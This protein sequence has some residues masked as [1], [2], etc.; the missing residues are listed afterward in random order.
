MKVRM[1]NGG[2]ETASFCPGTEKKS[3]VDLEQIT[4]DIEG[5][6]RREIFDVISLKTVHDQ[7]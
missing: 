6:P 5:R 3:L 1:Y 4:A 2:F 7:E